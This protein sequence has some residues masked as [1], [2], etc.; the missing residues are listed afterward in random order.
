MNYAC[1]GSPWV[2][3]PGT[4]QDFGRRPQR[5]D[6]HPEGSLQAKRTSVPA[7]KANADARLAV[8]P[9]MT[10][11]FAPGICAELSGVLDDTRFDAVCAGAVADTLA[12]HGASWRQEIG[13]PADAPD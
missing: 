9:G 6:R 8:N 2:I 1:T 7:P 5:S 11:T 3:T 12:Q 10:G 4:G 13:A